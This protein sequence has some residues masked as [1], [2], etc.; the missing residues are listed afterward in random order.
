LAIN[1]IPE[2]MNIELTT[3]CPLNC[4]QCYCQLSGEKHINPQIAI[5]WIEESGKL[6]VKQVMLSGGETLCYPDLYDVISAAAKFCGVAYVA[7]SGYGLTRSVIDDL[8][9][10]GV[11]GIF[12]SL[13][14]STEEINSLT[15]DGYSL[16]ISALEL[17][18][19][20]DYQNIWIN[21]VMHSYN[22]ND[23]ENVL[24]IAE[25]YNAHRLVIMG[26]KP[27]SNSEL[28]SVPSK[29]QMLNIKRV[30]TEYK[31]KVKIGVESCYSPMLALASETKLFGNMNVGKY[32]G[33]GAGRFCFSVNVDGQ[34]SPCRHLD[35]FEEY[36]T[37]EDYWNNSS[38]LQ[39]LRDVENDKREPCKNCCYNNYCRHC[40]A[41]NVKTKGELFIG[42]EKCPMQQ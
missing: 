29:E 19:N 25:R 41:T 42:N 27:D 4:P 34:L 1:F 5:K 36:E 38:V 9:S 31:G 30:I 40:L 13:N 11:S 20:K 35:F 10:A 7:L 6:G 26:L 24:A 14:G 18:F 32:K 17:L 16:A 33:C 28:L 8:I 39:R 23:F 37:I 22:S 3:Y 15:R 21:W 12:I 2:N